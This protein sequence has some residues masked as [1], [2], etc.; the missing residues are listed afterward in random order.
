MTARAAAAVHQRDLL[1]GD[2]HL[3][4]VRALPLVRARCHGH[5]VSLR[6]AWTHLSFSQCIDISQLDKGTI[7][8]VMLVADDCHMIM[9]QD[10]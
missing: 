9:L 7:N 10:T 5:G 6:F 3:C 4:R 8:P 2:Q 1:S